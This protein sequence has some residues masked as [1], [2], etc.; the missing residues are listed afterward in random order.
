MY[1]TQRKKV[2]TTYRVEVTADNSGFYHT[3]ICRKWNTAVGLARR[4][5]R[6]H[7]LRAQIKTI[8]AR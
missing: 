8:H 3:E 7:G 4:L 5:E 1:K 2:R 6:K